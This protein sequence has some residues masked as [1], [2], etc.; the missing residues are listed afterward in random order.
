L[1]RIFVRKGFDATFRPNWR[2]PCSPWQITADGLPCSNM[3]DKKITAGW[4]E[5]AGGPVPGKPQ[6]DAVAAGVVGLVVVGL[7]A[8]CD[9][10]EP[11][12]LGFVVAKPG[13]GG[14]LVEDLH[15]LGA[16]AAGE[17][18]V[19]PQAFSPATRPCLWA[20]VPNGR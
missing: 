6:V 13:A 17:L 2:A 10:V 1:S 19:P 20:V 18:T 3:R 16:K 15:D 14:G 9:R 12:R 5:P 4:L 8:D 11:G 7:G